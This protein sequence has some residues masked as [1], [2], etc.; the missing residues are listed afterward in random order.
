M[1]RLSPEQCEVANGTQVD[2]KPTSTTDLNHG[3]QAT[4]LNKDLTISKK[5]DKTATQIKIMR[6]MIFYQRQ[7]SSKM[8]HGRGVGLPNSRKPLLR[9]I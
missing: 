1:E 9:A 4:F 5:G 6:N 2:P 3:G 8:G 7:P